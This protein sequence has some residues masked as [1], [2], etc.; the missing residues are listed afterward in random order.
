MHVFT[1]Q[2]QRQDSL[3]NYCPCCGQ[4]FFSKRE[5]QLRQLGQD[6]KQLGQLSVGSSFVTLDCLHTICCGCARLAEAY[7]LGLDSNGKRRRGGGGRRGRMRK[8]KSR[9][10]GEEEEEGGG[11]EEEEEEGSLISLKASPISTGWFRPENSG[12]LFRL[13]SNQIIFTNLIK[14]LAVACVLKP[15]EINQKF[16]A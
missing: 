2:S 15:P 9:G 5:Q 12:K 3:D 1:C 7:F 6:Q 8:R 16:V 13:D 11:G 10:E 4:S 14:R